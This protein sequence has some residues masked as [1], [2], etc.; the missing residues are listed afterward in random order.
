MGFLKPAGLRRGRYHGVFAP[1][2]QYRALVTPAMGGRKKPESA[3]NQTPAERRAS[4]TLAQRL[5]R[6]FNIDIAYM[7]VGKGCEQDAEALK[8]AQNVAA[9]SKSSPALKIRP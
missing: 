4:M 9:P 3:D 1:H 7:D 5:K 2:S 8:R 6:V